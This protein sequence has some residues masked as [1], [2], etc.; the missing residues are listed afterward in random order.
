MAMTMRADDWSSAVAGRLRALA[1][2][3]AAERA[4]L[5][6]ISTSRLHALAY[7]A[8]VLSPVWHLAPF[9]PVALK[10]NGEPFFGKFQDELDDLVVIGLLSVDSFEY[11]GRPGKTGTMSISACYHLRYEAECLEPLLEFIQA[12]LDLGRQQAFFVALAAAMSRLPDKEIL[13]AV[14]KDAS[15]QDSDVPIN[16]LVEFKTVTGELKNTRTNE[17]VAMF[18]DFSPTGKI[19]G[20]SA[21]LRLYAAFL[22][23]RLKA[24]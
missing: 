19:V 3:E 7:L 10:T 18:D 24:A 8:D 5:T 2:V 23:E 15:W 11:V 21:K 16:H 6:P 17:T 9:D 4:A 12:D 14:T 20:G 1:V 13:S 22:A